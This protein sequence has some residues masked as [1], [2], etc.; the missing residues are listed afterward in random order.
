MNLKPLPIGIDNFEKMIAG[1]YYY[2]DKTWLIK[3]LWDYKGEVNL[4]TRPRR[5]GKT[6]N[7]S[8]LQCFFEDTVQEE[9][10]HRNQHLFDG[11]RIMESGERYTQQMGKYPVIRLSL[12]SG[13]Q[14]T[15]SSA[16]FKLCEELQRE[17]HRHRYVLEKLDG[18][19]NKRFQEIM[20]GT[21]SQD[22]YS[23]SLKFLSELLY[24]YH[25]KAVIILIDEY[26]VPLENA[27]FS[28]FYERMAD[29]VRSLFE[30]ALKTNP[31]LSFAVI[32]GCLRITKESIFTGLNNLNVISILS[33][34]YDEHFGFTQAEA[35]EM[36]RCYGAEVNRET[37]RRWYD[38]YLFGAVEVY[39]PW[40]VI[41]YI[42]EV[43]ADKSAFPKP[44]WSNTSANSIV[45]NLVEH[46][47]LEVRGE[48]ENL[49]D[50]GTIEKQV[51]EEITY[52]DIDLS[53]DNL[54]NFLFFTGYLK[55]V[56]GRMDGSRQYVTLAIPNAEVKYIYENTV[57]TWFEDTLRQ[58]DLTPL[59]QALEQGDTNTLERILTENLM[60]TISFY[61]YAENYYHGF[62]TGLLRG[63]GTYAAKSNREAGLGRPDII[64]RTPSVRGRAFVIEIKTADSLREMEGRCLEALRQIKDMKYKEELEQEGFT[65]IRTYGICFWKKE[66]MV[67]QGE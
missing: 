57:M 4:F 67:R 10:N 33:A 3:E 13:K 9:E 49:I 58:K 18:I 30:S 5:F 31:C 40:S 36:L 17:Y 64:L 32:T 46:A 21:A 44:Y 2:V 56:N 43:R 19:K 29:F 42:D 38:G 24:E 1:D 23:G 54:W 45:R 52:A 26:D 20:D 7:M 59:F 16:Y 60:E 48:I 15:F 62:L 50:G 53:E 41:N 12:K 27:Y 65:N 14:S 37:L 6:L 61:D 11:L 34:R 47:N 28:G 35:D 39:N 22:V 55:K 51:H 63:S 8:M 25:H 66:A